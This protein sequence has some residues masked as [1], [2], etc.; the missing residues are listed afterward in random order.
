M[1]HSHQCTI[2]TNAP[3]TPMHYSHQCT[4]HI[5]AP[6]V[7]LFST[8]LTPHSGLTKE[9]QHKQIHWRV[10]PP[11]DADREHHVRVYFSSA[12][13]LG[14]RRQRRMSV[15][16]AHHHRLRPRTHQLPVQG[17]LSAT[18]FATPYCF[19]RLRRFY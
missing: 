7:A 19:A 18:A 9:G 2:H 3:F 11:Q 16:I 12:A 15:Q 8:F 4:I 6:K 10:I 5:N 14:R 1:H 17:F 13:L